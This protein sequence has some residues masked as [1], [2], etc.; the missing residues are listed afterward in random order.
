MQK[1]TSN[2]DSNVGRNG[3][4]V[5]I[6]WIVSTASTRWREEESGGERDSACGVVSNIASNTSRGRRENDVY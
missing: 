5:L 2:V 3:L 6:D 4:G 1:I